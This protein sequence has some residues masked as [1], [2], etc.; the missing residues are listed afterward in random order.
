M[1]LVEIV[2][3]GKYKG[4]KA[5][6][7]EVTRTDNGQCDTCCRLYHYSTCMLVWD[8]YD[9]ANEASLDYSLGWGSVSDQH[10]MNKVF[11]EL[12][13]PLYYSRKG[14]AEIVSTRTH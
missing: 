13:I 5:G 2:R 10:G 3:R 12:G 6:A 11:R 8:P 7:W 1:T 14:G 4:G 9:P